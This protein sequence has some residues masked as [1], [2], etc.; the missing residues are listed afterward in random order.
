MASEATEIMLYEGDVV[1][2]VWPVGSSMQIDG[3]EGQ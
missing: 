2:T 3:A 1:G